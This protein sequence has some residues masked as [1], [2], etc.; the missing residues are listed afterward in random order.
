MWLNLSVPWACLVLNEETFV[1]NLFYFFMAQ[2]NWY[3]KN[4]V[5]LN[6]DVRLTVFIG[7]SQ[8]EVRVNLIVIAKLI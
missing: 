5:L 4:N 1:R 3:Y 8:I 7:A 6:S 2:Q